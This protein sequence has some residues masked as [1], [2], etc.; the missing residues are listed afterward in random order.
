MKILNLKTKLLTTA[1]LCSAILLLIILCACSESMPKIQQDVFPNTVA[2]NATISP[3]YNEIS[4][5]LSNEALELFL[6]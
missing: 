6:N 3:K 4:E 1:I 5:N 2:E